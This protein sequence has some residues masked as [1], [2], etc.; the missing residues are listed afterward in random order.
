MRPLEQ[1]ITVAGAAERWLAMYVA[2]RR[3][4]KGQMLAAQRVRDY[5]VPFMGDMPLAE[6]RKPRI[7]EYRL[8]LEERD[9]SLQSVRHVL[10]DVRCMLNWAQDDDLI[11]R[12]PFPRRLLPV[13]AERAPDR[14]T[15]AEVEACLRLPDPHGLVIR[16][17]LGTG[18]RWGEMARAQAGHVRNGEILVP[19]AKNGRVRRVPLPADLSAEFGGRVGRLIPFN[20][21]G[22]FNRSV[23]R[24]TGIE[25]FH[26]HQLR[27]TFACRWLE[28]G[29]SL[30]ALQEILGHASVATTQ[31]YGRLSDDMIRRE[32]ER[33][34]G[35]R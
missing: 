26:V 29:G 1:G 9:L 7:R 27:H 13:I 30:A 11:E 25:Q 22:T 35:N 10:A 4:R 8:S 17:G 28:S 18:L 32:A 12:S 3:G 23:R 33:I 24:M 19:I 2:A 16:F 6:L 31:R 15:D 5:L 20:T 34:Y 14:L 21:S